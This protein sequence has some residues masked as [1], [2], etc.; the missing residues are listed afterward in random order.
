MKEKI[1]SDI[2]K[3][4]ATKA[5]QHNILFESI[6]YQKKVLLQKSMENAIN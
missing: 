1:D 3:G 2:S 4:S 5:K 6:A